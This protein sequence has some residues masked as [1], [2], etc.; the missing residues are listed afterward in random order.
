MRS[1]T[2]RPPCGSRPARRSK[3]FPALA[4]RAE[5][6]DAHPNEWNGLPRPK[7]PIAGLDLS[8]GDGNLSELEI[9][10]L[11]EAIRVQKTRVKFETTV[12]TLVFEVD[13]VWTPVHAVNLV[14]AAA[15]GVYD[16]T[17]WH[18]VVPAFVIQGGD[19]RGDGSGD[20]GYSVPDEIAPHASF[21]RGTLGMPKST[22]DTGGC[23]VFVMHMSAPHLD[24]HYTAFGAV[25]EGIEVVD[26]IRVGDRILKATVVDG[27]APAAK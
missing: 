7:G 17:P 24:Q 4:A 18:R 3:G 16:G 2:P 22:K 27:G 15:A 13:P 1:T 19:P 23:Q 21:L 6:E 12:G 20:A 14:L 9:L 10:R 5:S 26:R 8:K 25:V 11:A